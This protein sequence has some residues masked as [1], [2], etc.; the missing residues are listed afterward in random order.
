MN[1][2]Q[3]TNMEFFT[4]RQSEMSD[5]ELANLVQEEISVLCKTGGRS[6]KMCVPPSIK[7]TDMLICELIRRFRLLTLQT[8]NTN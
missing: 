7:D 3:K 4:Q 2:S 8:K 5:E 1:L 6:I